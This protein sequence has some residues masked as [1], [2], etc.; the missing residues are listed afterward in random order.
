MEEG[1]GTLSIVLAGKLKLKNDLRR[2]ASCDACHNEGARGRGP[3]N[4]GLLPIALVIELSAPRGAGGDDNPGD[5]T[6]GHVFN[7]AAIDGFA[8]EGTASVRYEERV[9]RYADGTPWLLHAP[10][11]TLSNLHYGPLAADTVIKPRLAPA[12]YGDGLL[13]RVPVAWLAARARRAA[14]AAQAMRGRLIWHVFEGQRLP[15]RFDWQGNA[16]SI[17]DQTAHAFAREMGLTNRMVHTDDC[18]PVEQDCR[19]A[20]NGGTPEVPHEFHVILDFQRWLGVP[21]AATEEAKGDGGNERRGAALFRSIGC[22]AC[23]AP[24]LPVVLENGHSGSIQ[25]YTDLLLHDRGKPLTDRDQSGRAALSLW[26]TS[27][28]WGLGLPAQRGKRLALMHDGRART[29]AEAV[30]WHDG[31]AQ[32]ATQRFERLGAIQRQILLDWLTAC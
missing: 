10:Q 22:A 27:P 8:P 3:E 15:G 2:A 4:D 13:E 25:A 19:E 9:G 7:T 26:R 14:S 11:Y 1:E 18:T 20:P 23:H 31:E 29:I 6:Y 12:L 5:P 28:W 32:V 24:R 30:L 17:H 21:M 16:T